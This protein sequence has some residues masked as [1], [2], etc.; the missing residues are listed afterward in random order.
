MKGKKEAKHN[1]RKWN[2]ANEIMDVKRMTGWANGRKE[3]RSVGTE[4]VEEEE[5]EEKEREIK[6]RVKGDPETKAMVE[7]EKNKW[8]IKLTAEEKCGRASNI[9]THTHVHK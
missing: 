9:H 2:T 8:W 7:E 3:E 6:T 5:E 1:K 4:N